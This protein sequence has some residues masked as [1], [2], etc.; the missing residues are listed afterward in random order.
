MLS[1]ATL[2]AHAGHHK[3]TPTQNT[4]FGLNTNPNK[5]SIQYIVVQYIYKNDASCLEAAWLKA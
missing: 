1:E 3:D 5:M 2:K 4:K